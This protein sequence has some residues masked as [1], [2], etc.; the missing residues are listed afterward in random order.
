[1]LRRLYYNK[2]QHQQQLKVLNNVLWR[3]KAG[4]ESRTSELGGSEVL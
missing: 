2:A 3:S 1:V 4:K